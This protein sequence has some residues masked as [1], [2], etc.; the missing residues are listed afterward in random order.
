MEDYLGQFDVDIKDTEFKDYTKEN[1]AL[2]F[3]ER[4]GQIDGDHHKLWVLDQV[5][6]ILNGVP[7]IV[8]QA[9]WKNGHKE[10][11]VWLHPHPTEAYSDWVMMMVE[12]GEYEYNLGIAP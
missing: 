6:R 9:R 11:R 10:Y 12:G 2:Y 8:K 5:A 4:Y 1:W 7:V 3:I